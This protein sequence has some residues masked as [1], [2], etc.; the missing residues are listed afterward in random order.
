MSELIPT[1]SFSQLP[2]S[3]TRRTEIVASALESIEQRDVMQFFRDYPELF[4]ECICRHYPLNGDQIQKYSDLLEPSYLGQN[5]TLDWS[6]EL[7]RCLSIFEDEQYWTYLS[8]NEALPWSSD[9]IEIFEE[10]WNWR[11]LSG[12]RSLPWSIDLIEKYINK[13]DFREF[14]YNNSSLPWSAE[15]L[16]KFKKYWN[17]DKL[18]RFKCLPW[19]VELISEFEE[20][21]NWAY[22]STNK[23]INW[24]VDFYQLDDLFG[25]A[26]E[27]I[28]YSDDIGQPKK[29][30]ARGHYGRLDWVGLSENPALPWSADLIEKHANRWSWEE[31]SSNP[32]LPWS[33]EFIKKYEDKL[34]WNKLSENP[35]L[36]WSVV[37]IETYED[38]W[39]WRNLSRNSALPWSIE[40][41]KKYEDRWD[42]L[43]ISNLKCT[44]WNYYFLNFYINRLDWKSLSSNRSLPWSIEFIEKFE[45][46]WYWHDLSWNSALPWS[47]ELVEKY[48]FKWDWHLSSCHTYPWSR[49]FYRRFSPNLNNLFYNDVGPIYY[50]GDV[51]DECDFSITSLSNNQVNQLLQEYKNRVEKTPQPSSLKLD[52][53]GH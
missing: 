8:F 24:K 34:N 2:A 26:A 36:P 43:E 7:I 48:E 6:E 3:T 41:I 46:L 11:L 38:M 45:D 31:L 12:N 5:I 52:A 29:I 53:I 27:W 28:R 20:D 39:T 9:L 42:W 47:M 44:L 19:T 49:E 21:W 51:I 4:I 13:W 50:G 25:D 1:D 35:M 10:K 17:W 18:S 16:E 23:N 40:L 33:I 30:V 14:Y 22:L 37:L 32:M 15:L